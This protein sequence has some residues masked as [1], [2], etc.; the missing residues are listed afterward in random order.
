MKRPLIRSGMQVVCFLE[1]RR[2]TA[3]CLF[4]QVQDK[5]APLKNPEKRHKS[6]INLPEPLR[7]SDLGGEGRGLREGQGLSLGLLQKS[8]G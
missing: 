5:T 1:Y 7:M 6:P 2:K 3:A 8:K 4:Q